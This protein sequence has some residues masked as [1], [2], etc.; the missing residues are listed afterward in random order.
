MNQDLGWLTG[1]GQYLP[2]SVVKL[3]LRIWYQDVQ[4]VEMA[5]QEQHAEQGLEGGH[6]LHDGLGSDQADQDQP[7]DRGHE[8]G[9]GQDMKL[10]RGKKRNLKDDDDQPDQSV[11]WDAGGAGGDVGGEL[12][13][14]GA[15]VSGA[16]GGQVGGDAGRAGGD[17]GGELQHGGTRVSGAEGDQVGEL[18]HGDD[19]GV[20]G[21]GGAQDGDDGVRGAGPGR[22]G[23]CGRDQPDQSVRGD[24][25]LYGLL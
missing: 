7:I 12:Q 20:S 13:H 1:N 9:Q 22:G 24:E 18:G 25:G 14:G 10:R 17:V 15:G 5:D 11:L 19:V 3:C 6:G 4:E 23:V 21:A 8:G 2:R 16:K